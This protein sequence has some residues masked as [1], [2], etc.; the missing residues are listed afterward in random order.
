MSTEAK[1][2][3]LLKEAAEAL[4]QESR[5]GGNL[6]EGNTVES[7][8]ASR[9]GDPLTKAIGLI[10]GLFSSESREKWYA[11]YDRVLKT[12]H[13]VLGQSISTKNR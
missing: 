12:A 13:L 5:P 11:E 10:M 6:P 2:R 8:I 1:I 9:V 3:R 7:L 4:L